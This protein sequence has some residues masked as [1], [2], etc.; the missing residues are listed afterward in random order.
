MKRF[1]T[2]QNYSIKNVDI[3]AYFFE[4]KYSL[5]QNMNKQNVYWNIPNV[6]ES[7]CP[8]RLPKLKSSGFQLGVRSLWSKNDLES[9]EEWGIL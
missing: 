1:V 5:M 2:E 8:M 6:P 4:E 9:I 3:K 7:I